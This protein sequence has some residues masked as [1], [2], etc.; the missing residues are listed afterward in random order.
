VVDERAG[1]AA[2]RSDDDHGRVAAVS[3]L[4][5]RRGD[6]SMPRI[7]T[8]RPLWNAKEHG[9]LR[10]EQRGGALDRALRALRAVV[11]E[12]DWTHRSGTY[13]GICDPITTVRSSGRRK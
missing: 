2:V 3:F 8:E 13:S 5:D 11:A 10:P 4:E 9:R 6:A 12:Q 1:D 7:A